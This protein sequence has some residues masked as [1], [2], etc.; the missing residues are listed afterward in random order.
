MSLLRFRVVFFTRT[1]GRATLIGRF[2]KSQDLS[3][4]LRRISKQLMQSC[5]E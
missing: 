5:P 1:L 2:G 3:S 4:R